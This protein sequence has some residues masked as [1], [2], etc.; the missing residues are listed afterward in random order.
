M[1]LLLFILGLLASSIFTFGQVASADLIGKSY[2]QRQKSLLTHFYS[3]LDSKDSTTLM[4]EV[5][6]LELAAKKA[7]D[8]DLQLECEFIRLSYFSNRNPALY[9]AK[10][11][12]F[13]KR[14][15]R[16][17][18]VHFQAR[19]RQSLGLHHFYQKDYGLSIDWL[20]K[21]YDYFKDLP[22]RV[23]PDKQEMIYNIAHVYY[24][25]GYLHTALH[26]LD[27]ASKLTNSY[28][29]TLQLNI[30]NTRGLIFMNLRQT[31]DVVSNYNQLITEAA[32]LKHDTWVQ[33][34]RNNLASYF[35][36]LGQFND[37]HNYILSGYY[38]VN[39]DRIETSTFINKLCTFY[40]IYEGK[41][42]V[43]KQLE[44]AHK[45]DN[46]IRKSTVS[47][48]PIIYR[49]LSFLSAKEGQL[50]RS[51][52]YL[53]SAIHLMVDNQADYEFRVRA[54]ADDKEEIERYF[55]QQ[56][57]LQTEK[58]VSKVTLITAIVI[59]VL[60]LIIA[61]N[62][63]RRQKAVFKSKE[64]EAE[65]EKRK[66]SDALV[67][68]QLELNR[69]TS[70]LVSKNRELDQYREELARIEN[71]NTSDAILLEK[72]KE[73][74]EVLKKPILT[75]EYWLNFKHSFEAAHPGFLKSLN[76]K[77]PGL[78]PSEVRYLI[79]RK[80]NL[81][82]NEISSILGISPDS[83]RLYK[84]RIFKKFNFT[85]EEELEDILFAN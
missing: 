33:I 14:V 54:Q 23:L 28:Y 13:L 75:E 20:I 52:Q 18:I 60:L 63:I 69:I 29:P 44:Y 71:S 35:I 7:N 3:V 36:K 51:N 57:Q 72:A 39:F 43:D 56:E 2:G 53:D 70:F 10:M 25:I 4:K 77:L 38:K 31:G 19:A 85:S 83:V 1:R 27:M 67:E 22:I 82:R 76:G 80:L 17:N 41:G 6:Q 34:G 45:I 65:L 68:A 78:T 55:R 81:S 84:F 15:D 30:L 16:D 47:P 49:A 48:H 62:F 74:N 50:L 79:L 9:R 12:D 59:I 58:A 46:F 26:Y 61:V 21:S 24:Q 66:I 5:D 73:L 64:L 40:Q 11:T 37:A 8:V 32:N 42:L